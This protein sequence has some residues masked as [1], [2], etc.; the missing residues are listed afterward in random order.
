MKMLINSTAGGMA[1]ARQYGF[2]IDFE[3]HEKKF[4]DTKKFIF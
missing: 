2:E 3:I 1:V 4:L